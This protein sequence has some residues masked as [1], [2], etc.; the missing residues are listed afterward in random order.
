MVSNCNS[1]QKEISHDQ[2]VHCILQISNTQFVENH[3]LY[4][5]GALYISH[6]PTNQSDY[7]TSQIS[8]ENC[9][10]SGNTIS[11]IGRGAAVYIIKYKIFHHV[12]PHFE[13][14]FQ[15]CSFTNN[16]LLRDKNYTFVGA[17]VD[18]F[19]IEKVTFKHCNFTRNNNTALSLVESNLILEGHILFDGNHGI[20]GGA[21][22][23]CD[24]SVVY[25]RKN[26][27]IKFY[28]NHAKIAGGAIY[29]QQQCLENAPPCFFQPVVEDYTN[30]SD[31]KTLM[32]LTFVN[33]TADSGSVLYGGR[34]DY[35]YT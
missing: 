14:I 15:N 17:T 1:K 19:S 3:S 25:I 30:I 21:L 5:G 24:T 28:N 10:F 33:N 27:H 20:N 23:F 11:P 4:H 35:C 32:S 8:L 31:L 2:T 9:T 26:T 29:A 34:V 12:T 7:I 18:I 13:I 6:K 22:R 16:S